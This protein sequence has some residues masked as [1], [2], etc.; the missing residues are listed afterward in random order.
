MSEPG[1]ISRRAFVLGTTATV[2]MSAAGAKS[3]AGSS[4]LGDLGAVEAVAQMSQG[5]LTSERYAQA[6]LAKCHTAQALNA[7]ISLEPAQVLEA[8]RARDLE[9]HAGAKTGTAVWPPHTGKG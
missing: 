1:D 3:S 7:F 2:A 5:S 9:R 6:L 4:D 8:A